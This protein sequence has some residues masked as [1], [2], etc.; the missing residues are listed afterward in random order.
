MPAPG[1]APAEAR[2]CGPR[3][4]LEPLGAAGLT[5]KARRASASVTDRPSARRPSADE[6]TNGGETRRS[7]TLAAREAA[8]GESILPVSVKSNSFY[9]SL[10]PAKQL[11]KFLLGEAI[12]RAALARAPRRRAGF[13]LGLHGPPPPRRHWAI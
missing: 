13:G 2:S 4:A 3:K 1:L 8:R 5:E 6:T 7:Q 12:S 9:A 11:Q 10:C